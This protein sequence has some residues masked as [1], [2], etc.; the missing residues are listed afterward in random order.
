MTSIYDRDHSGVKVITDFLP[1]DLRIELLDYFNSLPRSGPD[2]QIGFHRIPLKYNEVEQDMLMCRHHSGLPMEKL[3]KQYLE[4]RNGPELS[5]YIPPVDLDKLYVVTNLY[6]AGSKGIT[7]HRDLKTC[8]NLV[9]VYVLYGDAPFYTKHGAHEIAYPA[10][11]NSLILMR[12][13]RCPEEQN[14]R[15]VHLI[16]PMTSERCVVVFREEPKEYQVWSSPK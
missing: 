15:P 9:A 13:A 16:K 2:P 4:L 6:L 10:P 11:S 7:P 1:A 12:A 14:M 5:E 8:E 3:I